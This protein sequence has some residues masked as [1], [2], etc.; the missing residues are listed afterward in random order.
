MIEASYEW[1]ALK[2]KDLKSLSMDFNG[3]NY[4]IN[5]PHAFNNWQVHFWCY[6]FKGVDP[7][8]IT[9]ASTLINHVWNHNKLII[10]YPI[11][12]SYQA[13][14]YLYR[15]YEK[16]HF[17]INDLTEMT[18]EFY[19]TGFTPLEYSYFLDGIATIATRS[20]Q[21]YLSPEQIKFWV[22]Y[23][24]ITRVCTT[25]VFDVSALINSISELDR[26]PYLQIVKDLDSLSPMHQLVY[27]VVPMVKARKNPR[28]FLNQLK[29]GQLPKHEICTKKKISEI[30]IKVDESGNI[31]CEVQLV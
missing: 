4:N 18:R 16:D 7:I 2:A 12:T 28:E 15:L 10:R 27:L 8:Q 23:D 11:S 20:Y 17:T 5:G 21:H 14:I 19:H 29:T 9:G 1:H 3:N 13:Q 31:I 25:P 22:L 30:V 26:G 24:S 6:F